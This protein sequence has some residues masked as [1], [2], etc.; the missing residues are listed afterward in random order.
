[1]LKDQIPQRMCS[2]SLLVTT[3]PCTQ[4]VRFFF[5]V[6]HSTSPHALGLCNLLC[7]FVQHT[8]TTSICCAVG[9]HR[10]AHCSPV[11]CAVQSPYALLSL[12]PGSKTV[13]QTLCFWQNSTGELPAHDPAHRL[14]LPNVQVF[15]RNKKCFSDR[16]SVSLHLCSRLHS[17]SVCQRLT[18]VLHR[19]P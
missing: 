11:V 19:L 2:V 3:S 12:A 18:D 14:S 6:G 16:W 9:Y 4:V 17:L 13:L 10:R 8:S 1:V 7:F 5:F 15:A